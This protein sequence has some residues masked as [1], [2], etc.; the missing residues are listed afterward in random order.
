[1]WA[2]RVAYIGLP[3][4]GHINPTLDVVRELVERGHSVVYPTVAQRR[5]E[6]AATGA[7]VPVYEST[8]RTEV[9]D[10]HEWMSKMR[11]AMVAETRAVLPQLLESVGRPDLVVYDHAAFWGKLFAAKHRVRTV[12][13]APSFASN[14]HWAVTQKFAPVD[15]E[16]PEHKEFLAKLD[17]VFSEHG[18][19]WDDVLPYERQIVFLPKAF[20]YM[21]ETF[22]EET[23]FV[24]PCLRRAEGSWKPKTDRPVLL[25]S[26]GSLNTEQPDFYRRCLK[27]FDDRWQVV[28]AIGERVDPAALGP[29]PEHFEV[30]PFVPQLDILA[31]AKAFVCHA[32]M[33]STMEALYFGVPLVQVPLTP[34]QDAIAARVAELGLGETVDQEGDVAAAVERVAFDDRVRE[35]VRRMRE[36]ARQAGGAKLAADVITGLAPQ[37]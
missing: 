1:M 12:Q 14:A 8:F 11:I 21:H 2:M 6:I 23:S 26:M 15:T 29:V 31:H 22:G 20:Q 16:A 25:I 37:G 32:G 9:P 36:E 18:L 27:S 24:G 30:M 33:G 3:L 13:V 5:E 19:S 28:M 34:E 7:E 35:N 4:S 10:R 17:E